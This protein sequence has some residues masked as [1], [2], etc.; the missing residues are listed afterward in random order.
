MTPLNHPNN[1]LDQ[2][3]SLSLTVMPP[4]HNPIKKLTSLTQ[5]HDQMHKHGVLIGSPDPHHIWVLRQVVHY[6]NLPPH[7][8][9]VLLAEEL[10]LWDGFAGIV[11]ARG[12]VC[13]QKCCPKLP[14]TQL[15]TYGVQGSQVLGL[16]GE[17]PCRFCGF[18]WC[19]C[20]RFL[21]FWG[22]WANPRSPSLSGRGK[23]GERKTLSL[24][25]LSLEIS[26]FIYILRHIF[27]SL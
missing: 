15:L 6:L 5:L 17:D 9:I 16:V 2:L 19:S 1:G 8:I 24:D 27:F 25:F 18:W 4:L 11:V 10:P 23:D 3:C 12:L 26:V 13:A 14:L 21:H 22:K 7:I 20:G